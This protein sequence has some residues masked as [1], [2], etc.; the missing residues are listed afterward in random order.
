MRVIQNI[1][2]VL[3][4]CMMTVGCNSSYTSLTDKALAKMEQQEY[5]AAIKDWLKA[6]ELAPES[7]EVYLNL[8]LC[9]W[10]IGQPDKANQM[11]GKAMKMEH[12]D[13]R[14]YLFCGIIYLEQNLLNPA[15]TAFKNANRLQPDSPEIYTWL[16]TVEM[17]GKDPV[18]SA[19]YLKQALDIDPQYK[20]AIYNLAVLYSTFGKNPS[21]AE[22]YCQEYLKLSNGEDAQKELKIRN[23]LQSLIANNS[24]ELNISPQEK[25]VKRIKSDNLIAKA[26]HASENANYDSAMVLFEQA[27]N[28]DPSNPEALWEKALFYKEELGDS[29]EAEKILNQ[30]YSKFPNDKRTPA[31][32]REKKSPLDN[33]N[34]LDDNDQNAELA[35]QKGLECYRK[36]QLDD[37]VICYKKALFFKPDYKI[38]AYNLGLAYKSKLD[39]KNAEKAFQTTLRLDPEMIEAKTMLAVVYRM[40]KKYLNAEQTLQKVI[41]MNPDYARAYLYLG[42]VYQD[43]GESR[44]SV[45]NFR[46]FVKLEPN[47]AASKKI[48]A[49]LDTL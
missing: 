44:K 11:L 12:V 7:A 14:V 24:A 6:E 26:K 25:T 30:F 39:Y 45:E 36:G 21:E 19:L 37:A 43:K 17:S 40:Q 47:S 49:W 28:T 48:Q 31:N 8:G 46:K 16:A 34:W 4:L 38:A 23:Y 27:V 3:V 2:L 33:I 20:P 42:Y 41:D 5:N 35:F 10:K 29:E 18:S 13:Y 15:L 1:L 22:K 32:F 9:Y